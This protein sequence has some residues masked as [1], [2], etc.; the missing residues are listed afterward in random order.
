MRSSFRLASRL[1]T[2][3]LAGPVLQ[4]APRNAGIA[5]PS[6]PWQTFLHAVSSTQAPSDAIA[7]FDVEGLSAAALTA[8][9]E[10]AYGDK[11]LSYG[12]DLLEV[13]PT[14]TQQC[15]SFKLSGA[16][17]GK[18]V[19]IMTDPDAPSKELPL[20]REFIHF[21]ATEVPLA[22]DGTLAVADGNLVVPYVG[23]GP[24]CNSDLHRY[25]FL[26]Y[27]QPGADPADA[28]NTAL[29]DRGGKKAAL[30]AADA[31]LGDPIAYGAFVSQWDESV[32]A[33]HEAIGFLPPPQYRSPKQ[34]EAH[35]KE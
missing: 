3:A 25:I 12:S 4:V 15:P 26:V 32:D 28:L 16:P 13:T 27:A 23:C 7:G 30:A 18:Y 2:R 14:E 5:V 21:V 31:G 24:P 22:A 34:L 17:A 9:L 1:S 20:F 29:G 19:V 35:G 8:S 11:L 10:V 6:Q 33:L